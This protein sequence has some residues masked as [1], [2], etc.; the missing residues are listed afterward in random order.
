MTLDKFYTKTETAKLCISKTPNI[1]AYDLIIEPSAGAGSFSDLINNCVAYDIEPEGNNII[2][3]DYLRLEPNQLPSYN[4]MLIIGNPPFGVRSSLAKQFIAHSIELGATTIAFILPNTFNKLT[5]QKVFPQD[6][7]LIKTLPLD[8][9]NFTANGEDYYVPCSFYIW[10]K[11]QETI[12]LRDKAV[13]QV[14]DFQFCPRNCVE[15]DFTLNGNNGKVKDLNQVAN[16]K[17]EHYIK[18]NNGYDVAV[19][20]KR[21]E[22]LDFIFN[23]SVNGGNAWLGQQDILKAYR[24]RYYE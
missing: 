18:V 13:A 6:W 20:R 1:E 22:D 23:S 17:A 8:D 10:T 12:D 5:N 24:T 21:L 2:Q 4:K 3:Q 9:T 15:A 16:P 7:H 11:E 19:I 14:P